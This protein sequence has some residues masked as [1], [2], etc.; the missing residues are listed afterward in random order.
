MGGA[1]LWLWVWARDL[2]IGRGLVLGRANVRAEV[3][4]RRHDIEWL[5]GGSNEVLHTEPTTDCDNAMGLRT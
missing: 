1:G 4:G 3:P 2:A 5:S